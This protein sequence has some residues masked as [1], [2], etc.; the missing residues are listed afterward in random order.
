[1][2]EIRPLADEA[3]LARAAWVVHQAM[4]APLDRDH[5]DSWVSRAR[6]GSVLGAFDSA[7]AGAA[8]LVG[9]ARWFQTEMRTP[10]GRLPAAAVSGVGVLPSHRRRGLLRALL[11]A[12]HDEVS[13]Q[14]LAAAV[15]IAAEWPIYGRFGYGPATWASVWEIDTRGAT[16]EPAPLGTVE[17]AEP[18]ALR[19]GLDTVTRSAFEHRPGMLSRDDAVWDWA[20]GVA[21]LPGEEVGRSRFALWRDDAG[22]PGGFVRYRVEER[23]YAQRPT[24]VATVELLLA[25]DPVAERELWRHLLDLDWITTVVIGQ[26]PRD[27]AVPLA[28]SDARAAH[29]TAVSDQMWLRLFDLPVA[30]AA[31]RGAL[32]GEVVIDVVDPGGPA[33]GRW[34][35]T[36]GPDGG[37]AQRSGAPAELRL[38][39]GALGAAFL[40]GTSLVRLAGAGHAAELAPGA[41]ARAGELLRSGLEPF[42]PTDF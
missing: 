5:L 14:G 21:T 39:I 36:S 12:L 11:G 28:L 13:A 30:F 23:W 34:L 25:A 41:L 32:Q 27:V 38:G 17:L 3:E 33:E 40:G 42:N 20:A 2:P 16:L 26:A 4:L 1:M 19:A 24:G 37:S 7:S 35:V 31:R 8:E 10:G 22:R 18:G 9:S 15:L 6:P 29:C